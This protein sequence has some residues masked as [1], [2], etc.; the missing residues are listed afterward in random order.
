MMKYVNKLLAV[1][2][3]LC[4]LIAASC[5]EEPGPQPGPS[6][7]ETPGAALV[8]TW[9]IASADDI[10][11][12][13][14]NANIVDQYTDFTITIDTTANGVTY[15]TT[16]S[17]NTTVFPGNGSFEGITK[18]TKFTDGATVTRQPDN[19]STTMTLSNNGETLTLAFTIAEGT[20]GISA[21][22][23]RV[24]SISGNYSFVLTKQE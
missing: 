21:G 18:D 22:N 14:E 10:S 6:G 12:D 23:A 16:G 5:K 24:N 7:T 19:V 2:T 11:Y 9:A 17:D 3:V 8:G 4:L 1:T 13:G 20:A 15:S